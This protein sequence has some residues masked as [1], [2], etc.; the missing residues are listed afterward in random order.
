LSPDRSVDRSPSIVRTGAPDRFAD[1]GSEQGGDNSADRCGQVTPDVGTVGAVVRGTAQCPIPHQSL[2]AQLLE[3][4]RAV[5]TLLQS[6]QRWRQLDTA[7]PRWPPRCSRSPLM[8]R[9]RDMSQRD[10]APSQPIR[11]DDLRQDRNRSR[12]S[13]RVAKRRPT[14]TNRALSIRFG[15]TAGARGLVNRC[16]PGELPSDQVRSSLSCFKRGVGANGD[17]HTAFRHTSAA[18]SSWGSALPLP[19]VL[20]AR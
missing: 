4:R 16:R 7:R 19:C 13:Q 2:W 9:G 14:G 20:S 1:S 5:P 6:A 12:T 18:L 11:A 17:A 15:W 10:H 8:Q 3:A